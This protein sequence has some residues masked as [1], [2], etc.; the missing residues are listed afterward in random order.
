MNRKDLRTEFLKEIP[1]LII[2]N[3]KRTYTEWL[4]DKLVN[5]KPVKENCNLQNVS[6]RSELLIDFL[7]HL[8]NKKLI[9]NHDFD[10]EK[11]AKKY[12]KKLIN[13]G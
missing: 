5:N 10:Y 13:C 2:A 3:D 12:A 7:I 1:A 9:N 6:Q 4:E 11:E 8:N